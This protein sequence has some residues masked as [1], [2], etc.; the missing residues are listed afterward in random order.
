M[1]TQE[2]KQTNDDSPDT[3]LKERRKI[4]AELE[5]R[6]QSARKLLAFHQL[7]FLVG[8]ALIIVGV[9]FWVQTTFVSELFIDDKF[10]EDY[11]RHRGIAANVKFFGGSFILMATVIFSYLYMAGFTLRKHRD[12]D[13]SSAE[14]EHAGRDDNVIILALLRSID[15]SLEHRK[16]ESVL[17]NQERAEVINKISETI[18][19]QLNESLL[20]KI[21]KKYGTAIYS[22]VLADRAEKLL[23]STISRLREY[24]D[25]LQRKASVNLI[26]GIASTLAAIMILSFVVMNASPPKEATQ[27][28][29]VFYYTSRLF[30][31]FLVQGISIF[32]LNLYN[33]TLRNIMYINNEI[34][35]YEAK[36]DS[37]VLSLNSGNTDAAK[38]SLLTLSMTE[39]NFIL[40]KGEA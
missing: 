28:V 12:I 2:D 29:A 31:V 37:L 6:E 20:S 3:D 38:S 4:L 8:L 13:D 16:L 36:R 10:N 40:R 26:W 35:N 11:S 9:F 15:R 17:S 39:R 33:T 25:K 34:T 1:E 32:F 23:G 5:H 30:L 21:E 22:Q 19:I 24:G 14:K 7:L 27:I 18:E